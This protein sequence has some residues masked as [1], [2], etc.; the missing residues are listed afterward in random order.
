M[1]GLWG[2]HSL[3]T[4]L[5]CFVI[6]LD[7]IV[8]TTHIVIYIRHFCFGRGFVVLWTLCLHVGLLCFGLTWLYH[9][10]H[11]LFW[12]INILR[13][14]QNWRSWHHVI[15]YGNSYTL[16]TYHNIDT[17]TNS[18]FVFAVHVIDSFQM[19][20]YR[21]LSEDPSI[22]TENICDSATQYS[23]GHW[24]LLYQLRKL[25]PTTR[26]PKRKIHHRDA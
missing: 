12:F 7:S 11:W 24:Q 10:V 22:T 20:I 23:S 13:S 25:P 2:I 5:C 9:Q 14:S 26:R 3:N 17:A 19:N 21:S 8:M 4:V 18:V 16:K 6:H 1:R 15:L